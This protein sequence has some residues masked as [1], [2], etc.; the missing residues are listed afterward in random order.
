M[1]GQARA[2]IAWIASASQ[3]EVEALAALAARLSTLEEWLPASAWADAN[4]RPY[5]A[6]RYVILIRSLPWG[7]NPDDLPVES[8]TVS[9][10]LDNGIDAYGDAVQAVNEEG[11]ANDQGPGRCRVVSVEEA[12]PV[13]KALEAAG[14]T[15]DDPLNGI[16]FSLGARAAGRLVYISFVP[17]LPLAETSCALEM[18]F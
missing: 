16:R 17:I 4:A 11:D 6:A 7:G 3:P 18:P 8:T 5:A 14:A 2:V 9:W 12:T 1:C 10:P 13:I 15:L